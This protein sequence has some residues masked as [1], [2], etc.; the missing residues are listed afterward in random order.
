MVTSPQFHLF[1][2]VLLWGAKLQKCPKWAENVGSITWIMWKWCG[3]DVEMTWKWS[4]NS[5]QLKI[6]FQALKLLHKNT[7]KIIRSEN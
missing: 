6:S 5:L 7:Y 4:G 2:K 3:N 1:T